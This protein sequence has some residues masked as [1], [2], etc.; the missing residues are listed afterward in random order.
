MK[1]GLLFAFLLGACLLPA[2]VRAGEMPVEEKLAGLQIE[3][4]ALKL[5]YRSQSPQL[6][7]VTGEIKAAVGVLRRKLVEQK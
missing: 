6:Q 5:K 3:E 1:T 7:A 4:A 2:R